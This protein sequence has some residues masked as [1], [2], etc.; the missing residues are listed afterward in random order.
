[1]M[2][3]G[4]RF[5]PL[6]SELSS[7]EE[8]DCEKF[9]ESQAVLVA[10]VVK[11]TTSSSTT[12]RMCK[13]KSKFERSRMT[14]LVAPKGGRKAWGGRPWKGPLP[15][16]RISPY[17]SL[18]D[19]WVRDCRKASRV[20]REKRLIDVTGEVER[21]SAAAEDSPATG[22]PAAPPL[23]ADSNSDTLGGGRARSGPSPGRA[24]AGPIIWAE[25][26]A[27]VRVGAQA[28]FRGNAVV[29]RLFAG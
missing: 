20:W 10:T 4:S 1:M 29:G 6:G 13:P 16:K 28:L 17:L 7:D 2:G 8:D 23:D 3:T 12:Q 9:R 22:S 24:S 25:G 21:G 26:V 15:E 5:W 18:G 19:I 11:E 14:N 27:L